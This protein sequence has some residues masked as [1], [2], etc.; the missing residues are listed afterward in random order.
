MREDEEASGCRFASVICPVVAYVPDFPL[1]MVCLT[2]RSC[3]TNLKKLSGSV[4]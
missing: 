1:E 3:M 4:T 2:L